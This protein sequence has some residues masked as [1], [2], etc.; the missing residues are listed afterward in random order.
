[1]FSPKGYVSKNSKASPCIFKGELMPGSA[2]I[3]V[4]IYV[5]DIIYFSANEDVE[6]QF[7]ELLS[8]NGT[9]DFIGQV[10]LFLGT[11]FTW[12]QHD[13]GNITFESSQQSFIETLIDSLGIKDVGQSKFTTPY[14]FGQSIDLIPSVLMSHTARDKLHL[15]YQS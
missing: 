5:D 8:K 15:Q 2:L 6:R 9:F 13:H 1:M 11:E 3:Y 4:G 12:T 10:S 14:Y 7:E